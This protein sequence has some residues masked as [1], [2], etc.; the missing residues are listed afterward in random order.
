MMEQIQDP[1]SVEFAMIWLKSV[2]S[3][4]DWPEVVIPWLKALI[5]A[6][7]ELHWLM[8]IWGLHPPFSLLHT[9]GSI[10]QWFDG[11]VGSLGEASL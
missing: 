9:Y 2:S 3:A 5:R 6:E 8:Q 4:S 7:D 10:W 1:K 11:W